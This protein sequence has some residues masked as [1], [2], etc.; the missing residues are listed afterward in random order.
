MDFL[1][2]LFEKLSDKK[3]ILYGADATAIR[4]LYEAEKRK[5]HIE[6]M[7]DRDKEKQGTTLLGIDIRDPYDLLSE[8]Y[9]DVYIV[10]TAPV[11]KQGIVDTLLGMGFSMEDNIILDFIEYYNDFTRYCND[12]LLG[13]SRGENT[14]VSMRQGLS[15]DRIIL[16]LGGS[17]TDPYYNKIKSWSYYLQQMLDD[18]D[19]NVRVVSGGVL[20]YT[21]SEEMLLFIR[22]GMRIH[23]DYV[24]DFSGYNDFAPANNIDGEGRFP[25][26]SR[27]SFLNTEGLIKEYNKSGREFGRM[28]YGNKTKDNIGIFLKNKFC[29]NALCSSMGIRY[30]SFLQPNICSIDR[31]HGSMAS[32]IVEEPMS[33]RLRNEC[34]R[35]YKGYIDKKN[36]YSYIIDFTKI[37][38]DEDDV[39]MDYV[40]VNEK[41]NL[42]IAE[43]IFDCIEL[44]M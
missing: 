40:H 38:N 32:R 39:F 5:V 43:S 37:I 1:D 29:M 10:I 12:S 4:L 23:P 6:Y 36:E 11:G 18:R 8:D 31:I 34:E 30:W 17:T 7:V 20:G 16:T 28:Y 41:G 21:S 13:M 27:S 25:I 14:L 9:G 26:T 2:G 22:D 15:G 24:V 44:K 33:Q 42:L 3:I 35:F 19:M